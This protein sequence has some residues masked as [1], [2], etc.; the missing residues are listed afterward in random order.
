MRSAL[1]AAALA[2]ACSGTTGRPPVAPPV[3]ELPAAQPRGD[4]SGRLPPRGERPPPPIKD[5]LEDYVGTWDG[6]VNG[7][8]STE[9]VVEASGRFR[10]RA[11]PTVWRGA[12]DLAGR[13]RAG[14]DMVWMDVDKSSCTVVTT[15]S[16][17]ERMVLS[18]SAGEFTVQ[19]PDGSLV[20]HYVRRQR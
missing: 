3:I 1:A 17:L 10:V 12:C 18:R 15:G 14:D 11:A 4:D 16:S 2:L 19:S 6:M 8:V 20:I 7:G 5:P 13:F 9:L